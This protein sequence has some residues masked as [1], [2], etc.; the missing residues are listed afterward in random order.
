[1]RWSIITITNYNDTLQSVKVEDAVNQSTDSNSGLHCLIIYN[2][3]ITLREFYSYYTQR[4]IEEK[5]EMV[6]IN[7]FYETTDV[8]RETLATGYKAIEVEQ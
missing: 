3:L 4:Q 2:D 8:V 5:N 1:M 6:L 7:P